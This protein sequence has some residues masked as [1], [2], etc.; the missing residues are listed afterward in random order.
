[1]V[2]PREELFVVL[3]LSNHGVVRGAGGAGN[4][5]EIAA[6]SSNMESV[7][8]EHVLDSH[9]VDVVRN[10]ITNQHGM[11]T[12]RSKSGIFKLEIY[13]TE[14]CVVPSNIKEA[15]KHPQWVAAVNAEYEALINNGTWELVSLPSNKQAIGCKWLFR[16]KYNADGTFNQHKTC[17]LIWV[18]VVLHDIGIGI[19]DTP[20]VWCDNTSVVAMAANPVVHAKSKHVDLD[21]LFIREKVLQQSLQVNYIPTQHQTA[22]IFTETMAVIRFQELPNQLS[23]Q[24]IA[25]VNKQENS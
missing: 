14:V 11:T 24:S 8:T 19:D 22:D 1:M 23:V 20:N 21:L 13:S 5:E 3:P 16:I 2:Q 10:R 25:Q 9:P 18:K 6:M 7:H 15:L 17:E 12:T 4:E